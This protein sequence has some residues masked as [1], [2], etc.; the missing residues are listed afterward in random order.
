MTFFPPIIGIKQHHLK[1]FLKSVCCLHTCF[2]CS[3]MENSISSGIP[4]CLKLPIQNT[5]PRAAASVSGVGKRALVC[6]SLAVRIPLTLTSL[7]LLKKWSSVSLH[8]MSG[9]NWQYYGN[10]VCSVTRVMFADHVLR[11]QES[12]LVPFQVCRQTKTL[13]LTV[14]QPY[15][16]QSATLTK[17]CNAT[18]IWSLLSR[19]MSHLFSQLRNTVGSQKKKTRNGFKWLIHTSSKLHCSAML[20]FPKSSHSIQLWA[21]FIH[22]L[23]TAILLRESRAPGAHLRIQSKQTLPSWGNHSEGVGVVGGCHRKAQIYLECTLRTGNRVG[24]SSAVRPRSWHSGE[25]EIKWECQRERNVAAD[26]KL[27]YI[28]GNSTKWMGSRNQPD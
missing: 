3:E 28:T 20:L 26:T 4:P 27:N 10:Y 21:C 6:Q 15:H 19:F 14:K 22:G 7:H 17:P 13:F 25:K 16:K 12:H 1:H 9:H 18:M 8:I 5:H 2:L 11:K 24:C 23:A